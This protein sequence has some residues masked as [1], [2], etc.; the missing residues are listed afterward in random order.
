M[1]THWLIS[2]IF[3]TFISNIQAQTL[4]GKVADNDGNPIPGAVVFIREISQG[5][6]TSDNGEFQVILKE[7]KYTCEFSSL[8]YEKRS[9]IVTIDKPLQSITVNLKEKI[10]ELQGIVIS[11]SNEDPAYAIMRKAIAMA[12]YYMHQ[13]KS[14]EAEVYLKGSM[15]LNTVAKWIERVD[16][17][18]MIKD[19]LFLMESHN[20]VLF[21]SPDK[22]EQKVIAVSSNFPK[23]MID[24]SS[25]MT[26]ATASIYAPKLRGMISPLSPDAFTYYRFTLE[27]KSIEGE[28]TINKIRVQ[29]KK[30][31]PI[32]LNGWLYIVDDS[33]NIRNMKMN[34]TVVGVTENFTINCS[35]IR[36]SVFLPAAYSIDDSIHIGLLK[37]NARVKYYSSIKYGKIEINEK[38]KNIAVR[39]N[40]TIP[41]KTKK[42]QKAAQQ[43]ETLMSKDNLSNRDAY[44][45]AGLMR[46]VM[47]SEEGKK[48]RESLEISLRNN[49]H[50]T[51]DSLAKSRDSVYWTQIRSL[52]LQSDEI[53]S[54][55][56]QEIKLKQIQADSSSKKSRSPFGKIVFGSRVKLSKNSR[57]KYGG[58]LGTTPE[59]NFVDGLWL[60][61]KLVFEVDFHKKHS[62]SISPSAHY[63]TARKTVNWQTVG[64][65]V[66][67]QQRNGRLTVSGGNSTFDFNQ[68]GEGA[69]LVNS[70][71]SLFYARNFMKFFQKQYISV[72]NRIDVAN[73]LFVTANFGYEKR[74][75]LENNTSYSFSR[76]E[77]SPNLPNGQSDPMPDN[78]LTG[79]AIQLEYTP[80]YR[81][82]IR[83][84]RKRYISSKYPTFTFNY[85]KGVA[86][87]NDRSASFDKTEFSIR[88]EITLNAFN[89]IEYL[90]NTGTFLSSKRVYFPDFKH[91]NSNALLFATNSLRNSFCMAN[92]R[93]STDKSWVQIH[94]NYTSSYLFIKNIPFLQKYLFEE[95]LYARTLFI[96]G[97]NY[98]ELGYSVGSLKII[99][100]GVFVGFKNRKY[101]SVG[102][103]LSLPLKF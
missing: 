22:Y 17:I 30:N 61:Q 31:N 103:T 37:L 21:T 26:L 96:P 92:Y 9:I 2:F 54:Y 85:E 43:L 33:W 34:Y 98:S 49:V 3:L 25:S 90:A 19:S 65:F 18:K 39:T 87:D 41:Q 46:D 80:R 95:S 24:S 84:G 8:G 71:G 6:L 5:I 7:G 42:Q 40:D 68:V 97:A 15:K 93:Y 83:D 59:Y 28:H 66:Y 78:T 89:R 62:L 52:P 35:E 72:S 53:A 77:P 12:P 74:N 75:A 57:F 51:I 13:V 50:V 16:E 79:M 11:A 23:D 94:L 101:E 47:E 70:L 29:P 76:K 67:S 1:K 86:T 100:A 14:Y 69:R 73:G 56:K 10:F 88:Q 45:I 81:Y 38:P 44:K 55:K 63:V 48:K 60:G 64:V 4:Q 20:E 27:G 82:W 99:E 58:L 91:Y 36:P 102:F 32:L